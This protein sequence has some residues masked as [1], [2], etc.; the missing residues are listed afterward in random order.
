MAVDGER[1]VRYV[2]YL[3]LPFPRGGFVDPPLV[4]WD[5]AKDKALWKMLSKSLKS[6]DIDCPYEARLDAGTG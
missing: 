2:V 4:D 6:A 5:G 1:P 3:R